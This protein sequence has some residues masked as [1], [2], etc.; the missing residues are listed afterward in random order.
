MTNIYVSTNLLSTQI[1]KHWRWLAVGALLVL[2][3]AT[4]GSAHACS[5][6]GSSCGI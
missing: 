4:T 2:A 3:F 1:I 5:I 6:G